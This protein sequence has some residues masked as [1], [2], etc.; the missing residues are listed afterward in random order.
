MANQSAEKFL[1]A[2]GVLAEQKVSERKVDKTEPCIIES[3][4]DPISGEYLGDIEGAKVR[5]W[6][7]SGASYKS[8]NEGLVLTSGIDNREKKILGLANA[9]L[10]SITS[11]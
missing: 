11:I 4:I 5:A 2:M 1:Y 7:T 8:G 10:T 9:A 6:A 3:C